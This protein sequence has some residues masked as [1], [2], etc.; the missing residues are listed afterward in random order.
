MKTC[1]SLILGYCLVAALL[2]ASPFV[3]Q[4]AET[5]RAFKARRQTNASRTM[6]VRLTKSDTIPLVNAQPIYALSID[7]TITQPHEASF[8]RIVLEDKEGHDYLVAE[9]DRFRNDT[10]TVQLTG[11]CEETAQL[12]GI[13]PVRLKCYMAGDAALRITGI[14]LSDQL[15]LRAQSTSEE[16]AADIKRAQVQE[17]VDRINEYNVRH[18]KLWQAGATGYALRSYEEQ[19]INGE[20]DAYFANM[21][22]YVD[23][24]YE[25]GERN[26]TSQITTQS[27]FVDHFDWRNRHGVNWITSIKDQGLSDFCNVFGAVGVAEALTN[28]YY[29]DSTIDRDLSEKFICAYKYNYLEDTIDVAGA[30][31]FLV[32]DSVIDEASLPFDSVFSFTNPRPYGQES[33]RLTGI[34]HIYKAGM[35]AD[36]FADSVKYALIHYGPGVWG[37]RFPDNPDYTSHYMTLVGYGTA[38]A[39]QT[40]TVITSNSNNNMTIPATMA[41]ST[42]WIFKNSFGDLQAHYMK[43]IFNDTSKYYDA[44]FAITPVI[45]RKL[46]NRRIKCEDRDGDGY[47]NWGISENPPSSLPAWAH[48]EKDADDTN[49]LIGPMDDKGN[50]TFNSL[51]ESVNISSYT[52]VNKDSINYK[53][54]LVEN[55]GTLVIKK[56]FHC[57]PGVWIY[58]DA[59]GTLTI[60]GGI[61]ENVL[62]EVDENATINIR[63]T[64]RLV[65]L[66]QNDDNI[67]SL[68]QTAKL[69]LVQG[70][71]LKSTVIWDPYGNF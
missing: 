33:I 38:Q 61:L 62:L 42:Y 27:D 70:E 35:S 20:E 53:H 55:G 3:G 67:F 16:S 51:N 7:A 6:N 59:G 31:E 19:R 43:I 22:Y 32:T 36:N 17:V 47:Y 46:K 69:N 5:S 50:A 41:G 28:I 2:M 30:L 14:H 64:G 29:N 39:G 71:I 58:V 13:T 40:Y 49:R 25:I 37:S 26:L 56:R 44:C 24:L 68:P 52:V 66:Q 45:S 34:K 12:G 63:N 57:C 10:A 21:K 60:D 54:I 11:Y 48:R 15:P 8:V 23:G 18:G 1:F 65:L 9:S 4:A